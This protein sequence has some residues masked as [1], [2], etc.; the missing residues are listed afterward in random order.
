MVNLSTFREY[1][2]ADPPLLETYAKS[3]NSDESHLNK[4]AELLPAHTEAQQTEQIEKLLIEL[5]LTNIDDRQ[6]LTLI[7][8]V[9][10][11]ANPI[12]AALRQHY[13]YETGAVS[14]A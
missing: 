11:A 2:A 4:W 8:I 3:T 6:R 1:L 10:N 14:Q 5:R 13:I 12:I 9:I 7:R